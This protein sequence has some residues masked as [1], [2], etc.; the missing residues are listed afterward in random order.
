MEVKGN[1]KRSTNV[2]VTAYDLEGNV[3]DVQEFHNLITTVGLGMIIDF[4]GGDISDGEIKYMGVG[5]DNTAPALADTTLGNETFRKAMT[6]QTQPTV[7][8]LLSTVY[9]S[10][11]EAVGTIEELG[12]FAGA[13]AGAGADS[14]IMV[15]RVLYSRTK[16]ALESLQ[17]ERS[18]TITEG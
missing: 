4:L 8:S 17:I 7:T 9:V 11:S 6:A 5:D 16:T 3:K 14:G 10:P 18:D 2:K 13:A 15:S 12:W 1:W